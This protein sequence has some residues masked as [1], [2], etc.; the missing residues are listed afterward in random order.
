MER[1]YCLREGARMIGISHKTLRRW[2]CQEGI[3][4][5]RVRHGGKVLVRERDLELVV[6]RRRT[7][8]GALK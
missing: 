4:P 1:H 5:P 6:E 7:V 2:L 8:E 3:I